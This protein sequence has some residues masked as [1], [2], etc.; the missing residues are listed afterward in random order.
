[1]E[2]QTHLN[3]AKTVQFAKLETKT[4]SDNIGH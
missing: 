2:N 4:I 1:M 3:T